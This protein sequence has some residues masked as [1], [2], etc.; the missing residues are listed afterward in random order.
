[1]PDLCC[2]ESG[3]CLYEAA[4]AFFG[5]LSAPLCVCAAAF[6]DR[7]NGM[8]NCPTQMESMGETGNILPVFSWEFLALA[9]THQEKPQE[10]RARQYQTLN[11]VDRQN[12]INSQQLEKTLRIHRPKWERKGNISPAR[13]GSHPVALT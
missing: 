9:K 13:R 3:G 4:V 2:I 7:R 6:D 8:G 5:V 11:V 1:V 12:P 10:L